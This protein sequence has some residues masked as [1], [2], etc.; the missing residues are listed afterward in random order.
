MATKK[1]KET[2]EELKKSKGEQQADDIVMM[3]TT[4][5]NDIQRESFLLGRIY[6]LL[7]FG[8]SI[9]DAANYA[10]KGAEVSLEGVRKRLQNH[11]KENY[12]QEDN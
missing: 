10:I 12:E 4:V 3:Y 11:E 5:F 8:N 2:V 1:T 6:A 7:E 9:S